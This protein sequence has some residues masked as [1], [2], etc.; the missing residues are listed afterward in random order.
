M[1]ESDDW[2][3]SLIPKVADETN[4]IVR[5]F[6]EGPAG[7]KEIKV[8]PAGGGIGHMYAEGEI[9]VREEHLDLVLEIL[10]PDADRDQVRN[11]PARVRRVIEGVALLSLGES[12]PLALNALDAIDAAL[13]PAGSD[14]SLGRQT[15][16]GAVYDCK[17]V[18]VPVRDT[19]DLDGDGLVVAGRKRAVK[20]HGR[21]GADGDEILCGRPGVL[22]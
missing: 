11:D 4:Y 12:Q 21:C 6:G 20:F 22:R 16:G 13:A 15:L 9:L 8:V 5:S 10:E 19:G 3:S 7:G 17:I 14:A 18:G 1:T 2:P